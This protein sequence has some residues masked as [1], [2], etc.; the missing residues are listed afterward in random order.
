MRVWSRIALVVVLLVTAATLTAD[1]EL[2]DCP[3]SLADSTPPATAF[4]L[5]PHGV[6]RSG[7]LVY[8]LRGNILATYTTS[9]VGDLDLVSEHFLGSLAG[10]DPNGGVAFR[11]GFLYVSSNAGLEVFDLRNTRPG[12]TA[13]V[14][15]SRTRGLHYRRLAIN[16][17][18]LAGLNPAVD[19]ICHPTGGFWCENQIDLFDVSNPAT[20]VRVNTIRSSS[21]ALYRGFND[22]AFNSNLLVATSEVATVVFDVASAPVPF[23]VWTVEY[24]GKWLVSNGTDFVGVGTDKTINTFTVRPGFA[25][26]LTRTAFLVIPHYLTIGRSNEIR[27]SRNAFWD[28]ATG[29]LITLIEEVD[30]MTLRAARTLAFDVFDFSVPRY[31]GSAERIYENVTFVT[32][33]EVKHNPVAVGAYVFVIGEDTG[34]QSWGACGIAT[35]RIEL[36]NVN[37]L[38]CNGTEIHG[39]VTGPQKIVNVELFLNDTPLGAASLGG[40][41]RTNVSSKTPVT[42]WRVNVNLDNTARGEYVLRALATDIFGNRRQFA[43]QRM[44]FPGPGQNCMTPR[45]R[46]VR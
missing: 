36:D 33:D 26:L 20:P 42:P 27:F 37:H 10:R 14:L 9:D 18:R 43:M 32:D 45:R 16:G 3:L 31:E 29:R 34:M 28:E 19:M 6:F 24:P 38:T 1:H 30:P 40:P 35:G 22:I 13:P 12:G 41:P 25:P 21:N 5:S 15:V 17:S 46:A 8:V 11:N 39:W 23:P 2:A 4:D 44:F 7:S